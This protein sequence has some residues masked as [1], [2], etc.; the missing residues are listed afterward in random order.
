MNETPDDMTADDATGGRGL[1]RRAVVRTAANAAWMVPAVSLVTA[2]PAFAAVSSMLT[3]TAFSAQYPNRTNA[4]T[5][6]PNQL[7]VA[8]TLGNTGSA[9]TTGHQFVLTIPSGLYSMA[10]TSTTPA[11][12]NA[13]TITPSSG[14]WTLTYTSIGQIAANASKGF[15]ATITFVDPVSNSPYRAWA[16]KAFS[17]SG[18]SSA[19]NAADAGS[20]ASVLSTV[21]AS[22]A[23]TNSS[24]TG[25]GDPEVYKVDRGDG[26]E[27]VMKLVCVVANSGRKTIDGP[28]TVRVRMAESHYKKATGTGQYW[29]AVVPDPADTVGGW[30]YT[31]P[32]PPVK[33]AGG[34]FVFV[35]EKNATPALAGSGT[36]ATSG[37]SLPLEMTMRVQQSGTDKK[38]DNTGFVKVQAFADTNSLSSTEYQRT[39]W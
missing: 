5:A 25:S 20:A 14:G 36:P 35:M 17:L 27:L 16:G 26:K 11:G 33:D 9:A 39:T 31:G 29:P 30:T 34:Y 37:T 3:V 8:A 12:F 1:S 38:T 21:F 13:P 4:A 10:P 15:A 7:A 28:I 32:N 19:S 23:L 24:R 18:L 6:Q 2:A 22:N